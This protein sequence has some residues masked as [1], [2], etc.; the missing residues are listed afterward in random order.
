MLVT[1]DKRSV[2]DQVQNIAIF[3]STWLIGFFKFS[4]ETFTWN[5]LKA[6]SIWD[7]A[8]PQLKEL[9]RTVDKALSLPIFH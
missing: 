6:G 3:S 1:K 9:L 2:F 8:D 5:R 7:P 4:K